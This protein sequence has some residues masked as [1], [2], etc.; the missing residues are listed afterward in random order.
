MLQRSLLSLSQRKCPDLY[1]STSKYPTDRS[2]WKLEL[3]IVNIVK[4]N[5]SSFYVGFIFWKLK[6]K[7]LKQF[8][9]RILRMTAKNLSEI[10]I[11][12]LCLLLLG[13]EFWLSGP[14][15]R[16]YYVCQL[17]F[18]TWYLSQFYPKDFLDICLTRSVTLGYYR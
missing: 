4:Q 7:N 11:F 9:F 13:N 15:Q 3:I 10:C 5:W 8:T 17:C 16:Q 1:D 18:A 2:W 14:F 6:I 12:W